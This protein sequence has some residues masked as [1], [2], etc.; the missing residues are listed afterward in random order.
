MDATIASLLLEGDEEELRDDRPR[1]PEASAGSPVPSSGSSTP[2]GP[3]PASPPLVPEFDASAFGAFGGG[4]FSSA[5]ASASGASAAANGLFAPASS[6][7]ARTPA[8][9][10]FG[11]DLDV[12]AGCSPSPSP[13]PSPRGPVS[14]D[15][16]ANDSA[17]CF[18]ADEARACAET[19]GGP[20]GA[21]L[22]GLTPSD[23][24]R[25]LG[26]LDA[27]R[28][29][30]AYA[31]LAKEMR[32]AEGGGGEG[33]S[34]DAACRHFAA[35]R[36]FRA[37]RDRRRLRRNAAGEPGEGA[38]HVSGGC[39]SMHSEALAW[40]L[41]SDAQEA[42]LAASGLGLGGAGSGSGSGSAG[43]SPRPTSGARWSAVRDSMAPLWLRSD[44][45]LRALADAS[46][47]RVRGDGD[48]AGDSPCALLVVSLGRVGVLSGVCR[49]A[50]D[51]KLADF[52]AR[53]FSLAKN[54]HAAL[55]N[56][57]ALLSKRR[58]ALAAVFFV[59]AGQ[60]E[61]AAALVWKHLGDLPLAV[62][63]AGSRKSGGVRR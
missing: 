13:S 42:L 55:K 40:A 61:D 62:A 6:V 16:A 33:A 34:P 31:A 5:S 30:D 10:V 4:V 3:P 1:D 43:F 8:R 17:A 12:A 54:Q 57:Y 46:A 32:S 45:A 37:A 19:L 2:E 39:A 44:A 28:D 22:P 36:S 7:A 63:V 20:A 11:Q 52:F 56:A 35:L 27:L 41:Q 26:A 14:K 15:S 25:L 18:A 50:R 51:P 48:P 49:A 59:L 24:V 23:R 29:A 9:F 47:R 38:S 60:P 53:D 58:H 21:R